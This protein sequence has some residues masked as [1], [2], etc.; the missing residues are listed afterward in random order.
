MEDSYCRDNDNSSGRK[1]MFNKNKLA[2][3]F[4]WWSR[5]KKST[6]QF[7]GCG[8]NPWTGNQDPTCLGQRRMY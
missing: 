3:D 7:R 1:I 5:G 4:P 2:G 6:F 8:F